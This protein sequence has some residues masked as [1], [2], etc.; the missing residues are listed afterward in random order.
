M[1]K[2]I[3]FIL[4]LVIGSFLNCLIY[5]LES[6][7]NFI[8]GK[9]RENI[10][11]RSFCPHCSHQLSWYDLVPVLSF[12]FLK[13][14]CRYCK[15]PISWQ[16]PAVEMAT[17]LIFLSIFN[18]QIPAINQFLSYNQL[19]NLFYYFLIACFLIIIFIYDLKHFTIPNKIIYPAILITLIFN[20]QYLFFGQSSIFKNSILAAFGASAFFFLI[21]LISQGKAIG[22]GDVKLAF[23]LGLFLGWPN[24]II[25]LFFSFLIGAIIGLG[26]IFLRKKTLKS[27]VP[28]GPFLTVGAFISLFWGSQIIAWYLGL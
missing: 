17:G 16:Y 10:F 24:I 27:E 18:F 26:L 5:C 28:F 21:F 13:G 2:F 14:K 25:A 23:F 19:L 6:K 7:D 1:Y 4:G 15:K 8:S 20:F 9:K 3:F 11:G 22:F 12:I